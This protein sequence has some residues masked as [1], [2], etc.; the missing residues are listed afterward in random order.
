M[1]D[2]VVNRY[3]EIQF[4]S[5]ETYSASFFGIDSVILW[6][7]QH[8]LGYSVQIVSPRLNYIAAAED[9][10]L[11]FVL[12]DEEQLRVSSC[13]RD[14]V[15][16]RSASHGADIRPTL[17][18]FSSGSHLYF[19]QQHA[20]ND[21]H[22]NCLLRFKA[23]LASNL[24]VLARNAEGAEVSPIM[25]FIQDNLSAKRVFALSGDHHH[26]ITDAEASL[27]SEIDVDSVVSLSVCEVFLTTLM[28]YDFI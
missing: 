17:I 14:P 18:H 26:I 25:H 1:S 5:I 21:A 15:I 11:P 10:V 20:M 3:S 6:A 9:A 22:V 13:N 7:A 27:L 16:S 4:S 23:Q 19:I 24:T 28:P 12:R 2:A 8:A